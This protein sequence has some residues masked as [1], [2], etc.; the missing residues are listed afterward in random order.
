MAEPSGLRV[1]DQQR[2]QTAQAIRD[3]FAAGRLTEDELNER[4]Q[5]A[6]QARTDSDLAALLS[7]LPALPI[8]PRERKAQ[9][10]QRR[11]ELRRRVLQEAGGGVALFAVCTVI[12]LA[13][14]AHGQFW[15]IWVALVTVLALARSTW[16]LYGPD[17]QLDEVERDLERRHRRDERHRERSDRRSHRRR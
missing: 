1:S 2:E 10:A 13:S 7:D 11:G 15:P 6:L 17:P 9:L 4:L 8:T 3:H 5:G 14:G 12:W 16:R